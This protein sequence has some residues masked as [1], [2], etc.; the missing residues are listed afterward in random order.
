MAGTSEGQ[1]SSG[2]MAGL[3]GVSQKHTRPKSDVRSQLPVAA[4]LQA[5]LRGHVP[6]GD[7]NTYGTSPPPRE[8]QNALVRDAGFATMRG[9]QPPSTNSG[10]SCA[11]AWFQ[12]ASSITDPSGRSDSCGPGS[13][14]PSPV[15]TFGSAA[16]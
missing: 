6:A 7:C 12:A 9:V 11:T 16:A 8:C 14:F 4:E 10:T 1:R 5:I 2:M 3:G 13:L 15:S